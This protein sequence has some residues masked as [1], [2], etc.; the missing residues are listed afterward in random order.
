MRRNS[1]RGGD[2][3]QLTPMID[4][5]STLLAVFM[6]TTPMM[7]SGIDLD[8]PSAGGRASSSPD[9]AMVLSVDKRGG[10]YLSEDRMT[11]DDI[12]VRLTA[13]RA[14]N[15]KLSVMIAGDRQ[16]DYGAVMQAMGRLKDVGFDAV[17][18]KTQA[19]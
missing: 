6:V 14:E 16:A 17:T 9:R 18:L 13:M 7:T 1:L 10:Y 4:V 19:E 2:Q 15:P 3:M 5:M 11:L 8:L 12:I